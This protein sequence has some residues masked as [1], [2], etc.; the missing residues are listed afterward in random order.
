MT[1]ERSLSFYKQKN[2]S[3]KYMKLEAVLGITANNNF[4]ID[5]FVDQPWMIYPA[6]ATAVLY[7]YELN[8]QIEYIHPP[9]PS[10]TISCIALSSDNGILVL[11]EVRLFNKVGHQP[12]I[13]LYE[14][15]TNKLL[16]TL[17]GHKYGILTAMFS[18]DSQFLISVGHQHD[19]S[20]FIWNW[21]QG[22][23]LGGVKI[24]SKVHSISFDPLCRF[25]VTV[26]P[27][28]VKFWDLTKLKSLTG[29]NG[30]YSTIS[31]DG[32]SAV[33][34]DHK[35]LTW[36]DVQCRIGESM[37]RQECFTYIVSDTGIL[38]MLNESFVQLKWL[39][40]KMD[41]CSCITTSNDFVFCGGSDGKIRIFEP[42]S[43]NYIRSA[44][45][46][47]PMGIGSKQ[48]P[49]PVKEYPQ[50]VTIRYTQDKK[51]IAVY[52]NRNIVIF[53][54]DGLKNFRP[55]RNIKHHCDT[56]WGVVPITTILDDAGVHSI[57]TYSQ[58]GLVRFWDT[59]T[60]VPSISGDQLPFLLDSLV[61]D[62]AAESMYK[63]IESGGSSKD[64]KDS[65]TKLGIRSFAIDPTGK[66]IA[67]GDRK[68]TIK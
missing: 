63:K 62:L 17:S 55:L 21:R 48:V 65:N 64:L 36:V 18:P 42:V 2:M 13:L 38:I 26:G 44:P 39:S 16:H 47:D 27:K 40:T 9:S 8:K 60:L 22:R 25:F 20:I 15:R 6:G 49:G 32:T 50:V 66:M 24:S 11:G 3:K 52:S 29:N 57:V 12:R 51:L 23:K 28:H 41:R 68:G 59:S 33:L 37:G 67:C 43:L 30:N 46:P 34:G 35:G 45:F 31:I 58:D 7:N 5:S 54:T 10:K 56:I 14:M 1:A 53:E 19:G 61:A 4:G